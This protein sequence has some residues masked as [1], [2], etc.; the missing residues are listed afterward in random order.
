MTRIKIRIV[1]NISILPFTELRLPSARTKDT[2]NNGKKA[3]NKTPEEKNYRASCH[4]HKKAAAD[5]VIRHCYF[6][7]GGHSSGN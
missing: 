7:F 6:I 4:Y 2:V 3:A 1:K 5:A